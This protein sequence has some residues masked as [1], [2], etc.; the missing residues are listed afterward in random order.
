MTMSKIERVWAGEMTLG[1]GPA[2][3]PSTEH[4]W[5]VDIKQQ[6]VHRFDPASGA[7]RS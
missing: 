5:F 1:E 7:V 6:R 4:L 2:W 3:D